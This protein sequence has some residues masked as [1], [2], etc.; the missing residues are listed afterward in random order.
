MENNH[1]H[2]H[3]DCPYC[4]DAA[5]REAGTMVEHSHDDCPYC[6]RL[7]HQKEDGH[8]IANCP[9]CQSYEERQGAHNAAD[10][11]YCQSMDERQ[12]AV[13]PDAGP[14][15]NLP[16]T[17]DSQNYAGQDLDAPAI[18]KPAPVSEPPIGLGTSMEAEA[19]NNNEAIQENANP[20][21]GAL[22]GTASTQESVQLD[23]SKEA[24]QTIA[25]EIESDGA[26]TPAQSDAQVAQNV[27]DTAL[28]VGTNMDGNTSRP[29]GF[30]QNTP[31]DM[32]MADSPKSSAPDLSSVLH[33]GLDS[34]ADN[35]ERER[36]IQTVS[37][38]LSGF[39]A[40][41]DIL[42]RA[43]TQAPQL[44]QSSIMMLKAMIEMARMLGFGQ[45]QIPANDANPLNVDGNEWHEPFP[46]HPD[47]GGQ[48]KPDQAPPPAAVAAPAGAVAGESQ[49]NPW[50]DPF[51]QHPDHGGGIG[52]PLGKLPTSATTEHVAR[53]PLLPGAI[54]TQGQKKVID[55]ETGK[56]RWIDM[57]E[58]RVQS[59]TGV[60][61]KP[62]KQGQNGSQA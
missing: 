17:Q 51:P 41:K 34:Q 53:T 62:P 37:Q 11:P 1:D 40:S 23:H 56:T 21:Q 15:T 28:A 12:G 6:A 16:T 10:C 22:N 19:T 39:K 57:K 44:Y 46:K 24:L 9:Y 48:P 32:G 27:D 13:A 29:E 18:D 60:P 8:D 49:A 31:Q 4:H 50:A 61:V 38:A 43:Q 58:G 20:N 30:N 52:Q 59:P 45:D 7:N 33:E 47:H 3:D 35:I 54:N 5:A 42:E 2:T 36:V 55:P 25:Q 26:A 14:A